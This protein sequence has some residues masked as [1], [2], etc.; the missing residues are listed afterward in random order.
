MRIDWMGILTIFLAIVLA[1]VF[2][3]GMFSK[4]RTGSGSGTQVGAV[5]NSPAEP[6]IVYS[7]PIDRFIAEKYPNAMR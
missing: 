5:V 3:K 7:N 2:L 4:G 1:E 6:V